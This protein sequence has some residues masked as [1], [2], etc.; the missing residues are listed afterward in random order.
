M[1][2]TCDETHLYIWRKAFYLILPYAQTYISKRWYFTCLRGDPRLFR[3]LFSS[4]SASLHNQNILGSRQESTY[5]LRLQ[6]PLTGQAAFKKD[7]KGHSS[8]PGLSSYKSSAGHPP[9]PPV[10]LAIRPVLESWLDVRD[11]SMI[12]AAFTLAFF[13]FLRCSKFTYP[14]ARNFSSQFNLTTD[15]VTFSPSLLHPRHMLPKLKSSKTDSFRQG[16][17]VSCGSSMLFFIVPR[18]RY[19]TVFYACPASAWAPFLLSVGSASHSVLC[20][21]F[22]SGFCSLYGTPIRES[23]R[24]QF[25]Y[26]RRVC[27]GLTSLVNKSFRSLILGLLSNVYSHSRN[28]L[29]FCCSQN[30][31]CVRELYLVVCCCLG[32]CIACICGG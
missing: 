20:Y 2:P 11:F 8:L 18:F 24:S 7:F 16:Q 3:I 22:T 21:A 10:L 1:F 23:K 29:A 25:S 5:S 4:Y 30:G 28:S 15:C 13:A 12:W 31:S 17:T 19:A 6:W 26:R 32:W 27:C 14:G 9:P